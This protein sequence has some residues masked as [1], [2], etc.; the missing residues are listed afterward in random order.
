MRQDAGGAWRLPGGM[1]AMDDHQEAE[2]VGATD[3]KSSAERMAET[4]AR[5]LDAVLDT[6]ADRGYAGTT[7]NEIARRSG[8]TRGAQLHHFGTKERMI[9]AAVEH[10]SA[11]TNAADIS[12]ALEH[13]PEGQDRLRTV[14]E[15]MSQLSLGALPAAYVELWVASR[16]HPE[17][18]DALRD[19]D[20]VAR[21]AVRSLFGDDILERAGREFD[22]LLDLTLYA[23]RG[24]ALDAHL[25][26][27]DELRARVELILGMADYLEQAL[28]AKD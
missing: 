25:A 2:P 9:V 20:V 17:L 26:S 24:M 28:E 6:L 21:D 1:S 13:L 3:R 27:D 22:D 11:R 10:L 23:L 18:V 4:H 5:L 19:S 7:T 12:A 16:T 15:I 14:L 8:L